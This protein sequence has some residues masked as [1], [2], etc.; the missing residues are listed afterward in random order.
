MTVHVIQLASF[1]LLSVLCMRTWCIE[2]YKRSKWFI[3]VSCDR[4]IQRSFEIGKKYRRLIRLKF[5]CSGSIHT[6]AA[7]TFGV[8]K[9]SFYFFDY[10]S[11]LLRWKQKSIRFISHL[12]FSNPKNGRMNDKKSFSTSLNQ[13]FRWNGF[14]FLPWS[15]QLNICAVREFYMRFVSTFSRTAWPKKRRAR[16]SW[17]MERRVRR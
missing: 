8:K 3:C 12:S 10:D 1:V 6:F 2:V 15:V 4:S 11:V 5:K 16:I 7:A 9:S 14:F 17:K 13:Q